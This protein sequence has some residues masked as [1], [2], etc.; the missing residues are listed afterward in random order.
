[1]LN[2]F[3]TVH[4]T[5]VSDV[6]PALNAGWSLA[7]WPMRSATLNLPPPVR[8]DTTRS[9]APYDATASLRCGNTHP[10]RGK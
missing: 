10:G 1:M 8:T 3:H 7:A 6:R 5:T 2:S 9:V 4:N